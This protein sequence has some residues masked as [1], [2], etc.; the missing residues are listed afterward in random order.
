M[1]KIIILVMF[2][3]VLI[4]AGVMKVD[5]GLKEDR[6]Y[7]TDYACMSDCLNRYSYQYCKSICS[8]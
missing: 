4:T 6:S 3:A 2:V 8:Y 5:A 7:G 1:K